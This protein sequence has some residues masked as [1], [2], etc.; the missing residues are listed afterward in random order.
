MFDNSGGFK[1][2]KSISDLM[3]SVVTKGSMQT[4]TLYMT[5]NETIIEYR[6]AVVINGIDWLSDQVDLLQR[7]IMLELSPISEED[8]KTEEELEAESMRYCRICLVVY[9][10][11]FRVF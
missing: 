5:K 11:L 10:M 7:S 9:M 4:R 1:H 6:S 8:R 3:C 2:K